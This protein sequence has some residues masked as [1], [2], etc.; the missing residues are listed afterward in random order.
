[1]SFLHGVQSTSAQSHVRN[2]HFFNL[3]SLDNFLPALGTNS[4]S[5]VTGVL[6]PIEDDCS[7]IEDSIAI[8]SS[9]LGG[10]TFTVKPNHI[11][12][13][14]FGTC[15]YFFQNTGKDSATQ[16]WAKF[17]SRTERRSLYKGMLKEKPYFSPQEHL[18]LVMPASLLPNLSSLKASAL[19]S[20]KTGPWGKNHYF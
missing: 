10:T 9:Q 4:C 14:S 12:A 5:N 13:L 8:L 3:I 1:M 2:L 20:R 19:P 11:M 18:L 15:E 16:C 17:V 6:P 7:T